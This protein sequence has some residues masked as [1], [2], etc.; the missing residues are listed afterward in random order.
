M[1]I[2]VPV[3]CLVVLKGL[4]HL[5]KMCQMYVVCGAKYEVDAAEH[6][7]D[8]CFSRTVLNLIKK[9]VLIFGLM[10][11]HEGIFGKKRKPSRCYK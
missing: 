9:S 7:Y 6:D 8:I 10:T 2:E 4:S 5:Q 1:S 11:S 3:I